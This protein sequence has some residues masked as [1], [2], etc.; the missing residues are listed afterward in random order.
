MRWL[1]L[2]LLG[3]MLSAPA[4]A[5]PA[6]APQACAAEAAGERILCHAMVVPMAPAEVWRLI[7]TSEGWQSWAAPVAHVD[8]RT[9][10]GIET[11]YN[12]AGRIGDAGNIRNRVIAFTPERL[13]VIQIADAPPGFPHADLA[14]ELTTALELEPLGA[15]QTR[16][17]ITMMGFR[18]APGFD[19]LYDFFDRGN[20]FTLT[21][22]SERAERGPLDE[23]AGRQ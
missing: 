18:D 6:A 23:Q 17:R 3:G 7:S 22:L 15:G 21:K 13:L 5:Q 2:A 16:V 11:S 9:G 14:R 10:G 4:H 8:L 12:P 20:A 19:A 1:A